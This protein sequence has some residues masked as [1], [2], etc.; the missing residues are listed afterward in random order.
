MH[1]VRIS[2]KQYRKSTWW[3]QWPTSGI[4]CH[5]FYLPLPFFDE[6]R[7]KD[8]SWPGLEMQTTQSTVDSYCQ[9]V[10]VCHSLE[11]CSK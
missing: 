6:Y 7:K 5:C 3:L 8:M 1:T 10:L 2:N 4:L 9:P 11:I